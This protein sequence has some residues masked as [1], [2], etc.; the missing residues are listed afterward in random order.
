MTYSPPRRLSRTKYQLSVAAIRASLLLGP[1]GVLLLSARGNAASPAPL[2]LPAHRA[3]VELGVKGQAPL[4]F[5]VG[6]AEGDRPSRVSLREG[7]SSY[8]LSVSRS[9]QRD[10]RA[11]VRLDIHWTERPGRPRRAGAAQPPRADGQ[12]PRPEHGPGVRM[13]SFSTSSVVQPGK[14]A[15]LGQLQRGNGDRLFVALT[16]K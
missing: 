9:M 13:A 12:Q 10:G 14:R 6:L 5:A 7:R 8:D 1:V 3:V 15:V 16:I 4:R 11:L 2:A